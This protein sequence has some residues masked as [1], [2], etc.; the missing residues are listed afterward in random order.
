VLLIAHRYSTVSYADRVVILD[1]G[2]VVA[3]G[4]PADLLMSSAT[5]RDFVRGQ[6]TDGLESNRR[7]MS[8]ADGAS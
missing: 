7:L 3:Q 5:Y 8:V 4:T 2:R 6:S 1:D